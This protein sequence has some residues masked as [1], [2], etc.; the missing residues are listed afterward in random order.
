MATY[1]AGT[2][3]SGVGS[4]VHKTLTMQNAYTSFT[5]YRVG[6]YDPAKP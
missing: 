4:E 5:P 2:Y 3:V 1:L 6:Y